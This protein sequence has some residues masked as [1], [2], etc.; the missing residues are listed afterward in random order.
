MKHPP[1]PLYPET[2][3]QQPASGSFKFIIPYEHVIAKS[4]IFWEY[5]ESPKSITDTILGF[6]L[7]FDTTILLSLISL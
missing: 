5:I 4:F 6:T 3:S 2:I 7:S 1:T